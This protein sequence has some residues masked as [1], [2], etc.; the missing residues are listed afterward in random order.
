MFRRGLWVNLL[1]PKAIVFFLAFLP[2]FIRPADPLLPQYATVAAT[3]VA[4]RIRSLPAQLVARAADGTANPVP[5]L[6]ELRGE[7]YVGRAQFARLNRERQKG[8]IVYLGAG[9]PNL[10]STRRLA[11]ASAGAQAPG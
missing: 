10:E 7:V 3:A 9:D 11:L 8:F 4:R 5:E 6:I 2:Q 1:N